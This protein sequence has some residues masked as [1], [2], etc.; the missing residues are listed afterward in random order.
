MVRA[1]LSKFL[2]DEI[3][4]S[5]SRLVTLSLFTQR[6]VF[7]TPVARPRLRQDLALA[8]VSSLPS[9]NHR[10]IPYISAPRENVGV[11]LKLPSFHFFGHSISSMLVNL[12]NTSVRITF[13]G[14]ASLTVDRQ[15]QAIGTVDQM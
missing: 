10:T 4:F 14:S 3:L 13:V 8:G 2:S 6:F 15:G 7:V 9:I 11:H 5:P 12:P 1:S